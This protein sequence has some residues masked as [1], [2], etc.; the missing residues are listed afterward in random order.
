MHV[1]LYVVG[2]VL[3]FY[4]GSSIFS[5]FLFALAQV[6]EMLRNRTYIYR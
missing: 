1:V 4:F 5:L 2:S 3:V 6:D